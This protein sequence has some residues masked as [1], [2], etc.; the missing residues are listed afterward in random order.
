M[1]L[2]IDL[3]EKRGKTYGTTSKESVQEDT[4]I[5]RNGIHMKNRKNVMA[6]NPK[7][8]VVKLG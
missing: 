1:D 2:N 7:H 8:Y 5:Y 3:N 6:S 4:S